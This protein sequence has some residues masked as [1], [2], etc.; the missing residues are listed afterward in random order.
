M[1]A[2]IEALTHHGL[3]ALRLVT[4]QGARAVLTLF[5][6]QVL[7]WVPP[8]GREWLYV[9]ERAGFDGRQ[10]IRGGVPVCFPQFAA[11]GPLPK[12]GFARLREWSL[13]DQ[14]ASRDFTQVSLS[15]EPTAEEAALWPSPYRAELTVSLAENRLDL[16]L[17]VANTGLQA[18]EFTA[19]LHT[20]LRVDEVEEAR[21][22]GLHGHYFEDATRGGEVRRDSGD[23]LVVE[24]EVDR[25]Y[26]DVQ[27][28]LLLRDAGRALGIHGENFPD[29]VVWNPWE[30]KA[31]ALADLPPHGFRHMLCVEAAAATQPVRVEPGAD[32]WGRQT[33]VAL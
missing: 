20:Y 22:E 13:S 30:A 11:R 28:A 27:G 6:A 24:D 14:R 1:T 29:V 9:S 10:A 15:L 8:G 33:L 25:L 26:R 5:G 19:A 31:A 18:L 21:L 2:A 7:S 12:H 4:P 3:P 32:W 23:A 17:E 16:E